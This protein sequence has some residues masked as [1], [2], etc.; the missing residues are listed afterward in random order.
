MA[1]SPSRLRQ[2]AGT[3][4][5]AVRCAA[6]AAA[7]VAGVA[8]LAPGARGQPAPPPEERPPAWRRSPPTSQARPGPGRAPG[9]DEAGIIELQRQMLELRRD[10]LDEREKRIVRWQ[11]SNGTVLVVLGIAIGIGGIWAYAKFRAIATQAEMG[12]A[13]ARG[14][15]YSPW[16]GLPPPGTAPA[17]QGQAPHPSS[18]LVGAG[19]GAGDPAAT[20]HD[21]GGHQAVPDPRGPVPDSPEYQEAAAECTE[22]IRLDPDH[23]HAWLERG[24]LK[25]RHG[26]YEGAIADYDQAIRLD[27]RNA[28]AYMNRSLAKS[29]LE[30]HDEA[31][32]DLDKA[33][34]LDPDAVSE[35]D[36]P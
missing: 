28:G 32:E 15:A 31:L 23:P 7:L 2:P 24:D 34:R 4:T 12:M 17:L 11:E 13:V 19:P 9:P 20:G 18:L 14:H 21:P 29:E 33:M 35:L 26:Q 5:R 16:G 22:A 25:A 1:P 8:A 30:R 6:A 3:L 10:L 27:P 36:G